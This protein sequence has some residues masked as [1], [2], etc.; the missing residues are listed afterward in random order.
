[1]E[2]DLCPIEGTG[3]FDVCVTKAKASFIGW[4][5]E[6]CISDRALEA[7]EWIVLRK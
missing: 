2:E 6:V 4:I 5:H 1:M 3:L 7:E